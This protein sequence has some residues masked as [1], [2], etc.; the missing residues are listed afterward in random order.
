MSTPLRKMI[1]ERAKKQA[2]GTLY[3]SYRRRK[4]RVLVRSSPSGDIRRAQ[5]ALGHKG[6][7]TMAWHYVLD[8]LDEG[9][10]GD[11]Y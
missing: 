1:G 6:I 9:L 4:L 7:D 11:L 3:V 5:K 10:T 8:E 2:M